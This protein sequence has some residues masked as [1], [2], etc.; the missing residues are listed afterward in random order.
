MCKVLYLY[1]KVHTSLFLVLCRST[2]S[3][4]LQTKTC[5]PKVSVLDR[6]VDR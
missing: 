4:A 2:K 6:N 5:R 3:P 1:Q